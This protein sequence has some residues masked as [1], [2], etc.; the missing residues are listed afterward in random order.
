MISISERTGLENLHVES[1]IFERK[2]RSSRLSEGNSLPPSR[3]ER[4]RENDP[5]F[6]NRF[7]CF[8]TT[9]C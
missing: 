1:D 6:G 8:S 5:E 9:F 7:P 2:W 4:S 3:K